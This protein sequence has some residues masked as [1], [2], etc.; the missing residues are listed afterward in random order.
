MTAKTV[1]EESIR[2]SG[3]QRLDTATIS[4]KF[5]DAVYQAERNNGHYKLSRERSDSTG[6]TVDRLTNDSFIRTIDGEKIIVADSM[7]QRYSNSINS[8]H[9]FSAL[10]FGLDDQAVKLKYIDSVEIK[11]KPYHKIEVSFAEE[12]GGTDFEDVF[13]YWIHRDTFF[14]DY[15]AYEFHVNGGGVRFREAYNERFV[16]G[17]R[18]VDYNNYKP[19]SDELK[20]K[21]TDDAFAQNKLELLSKI[22]LEA[23]KINR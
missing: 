7:V 3:S 19:Q 16:S 12:G 15:L 20:L 6:V 23:V 1:I 10:P 14:V 22:E 18:I 8:V 4:F 9:Y 11:E 13:I 2:A 17:V 21:E 5:R